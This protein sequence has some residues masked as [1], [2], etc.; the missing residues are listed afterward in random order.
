MCR[1]S[2]GD[3]AGKATS[4]MNLYTCM[5]N[6]KY[7]K[8]NIRTNIYDISKNLIYMYIYTQNY[9]TTKKMPT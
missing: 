5:Y 7:E 1:K 6:M 4:S 3:G 8:I 2:V 9:F